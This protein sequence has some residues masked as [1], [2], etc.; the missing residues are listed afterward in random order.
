MKI[1][2]DIDDTI[3]SFYK[4]FTEFC[5]FKY[6]L[7]LSVTQVG[8]DFFNSLNSKEEVLLT[9]KE[10]I[11]LGNSHSFNLFEDFK[12]VFGELDNLFEIVFITSR[13]YDLREKTKEMLISKLN[14]P[15]LEVYYTHDFLVPKK[16]FVCKQNNVKILIEDDRHNSLDCA[17]EGIKVLLLDKPWNKN[18]PSHPN[19]IKVLNWEEVLEKIK[20]LKENIK[21]SNK[22]I[23]RV[24]KFVEEETKK[25]TSFY[26]LAYELHFV[27]M[28]KIA[29]ELAEKLGADV[30][31]VEIAAW[32]H[33]IGSVIK[34]RENHHI[35]GAK[36]AE[37]KL[38]ELNYPEDK[39]EKVKLCI[40]NHRGSKEKTNNRSFVEAQIIVDADALDAFNNISKQFLITLV[41]EGLSLNEAR[42]SIKRKLQ[43]KWNQLSLQEA[44]ELIKPKYD[45]AMLLLGD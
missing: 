29:K 20:N 39:I 28:V 1:G 37:E 9:L 25:E 32:L 27:S 41:Y 38:R 30:E 45:A 24:R 21:T 43:N 22:I 19:L 16:S 15:N 26:P 31:L 7:N 2:I 17:K 12:K 23:E 40:L 13:S 33:D 11:D 44:K 42:D 3:L 8:L 5:N 14:F 10:F 35:T 4:E 18:C 36:I 6:N 34:C